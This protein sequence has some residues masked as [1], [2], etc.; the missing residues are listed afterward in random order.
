MR[1][2]SRLSIPAALIV[3]VIFCSTNAHGQLDGAEGYTFHPNQVVQVASLPSAVADSTAD[4]DV[5][6][7]SVAS[8]VMDPDICC[9]RKSALVD[10]LGSVTTFSLPQL[11]EKLRGKRYLDSGA[12][13]AITDQYWPAA[14]VH[15]EEIIATLAAQ[16]PLLMVWKGHLYVVSGAIFDE[17]LYYSGA[18]MCVIHKLLLVDTRFSGKRRHVTFD[19]Q[20]DDWSNVTGLLSLAVTR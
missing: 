5:L 4:T 18:N 15:A 13:F 8:A 16:R 10:Q 20:T 12:S 17:Y 6:T 1:L 14:A 2:P 11:G 7:A 9:D 19:R 3:L